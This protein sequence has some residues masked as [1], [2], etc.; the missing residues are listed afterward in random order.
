MLAVDAS[1][2]AAA[3]SYSVYLQ[4]GI[5]DLAEDSVG[6]ADSPDLDLGPSN[7][8]F[9]TLMV[10]SNLITQLIVLLTCWSRPADS[11]EQQSSQ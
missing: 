4:R 3:L 10:S 9:C 2:L 1:V 8:S 11:K 7:L 5:D 6:E